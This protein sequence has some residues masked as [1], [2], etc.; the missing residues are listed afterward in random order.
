MAIINN[1]ILSGGGI[2]SAHLI[3]TLE[4]EFKERVTWT[5]DKDYSLLAVT[6]HWNNINENRGWAKAIYS[7][8]DDHII[9]DQGDEGGS[10]VSNNWRFAILTK[11]KK[12]QTIKSGE[13]SIT[14]NSPKYTTM[15]V[16]E[17]K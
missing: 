12:G 17:L 2:K 10:N 15:Y 8:G 13:Q 9:L 14:G 5:A 7:G 6:I 1:M 4:S 3:S 11:V 16:Y